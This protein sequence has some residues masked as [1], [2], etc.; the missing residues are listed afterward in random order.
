MW[1]M[2]FTLSDDEQVTVETGRGYHSGF[3]EGCAQETFT[4]LDGEPR[5][6]RLTE[7]CELADPKLP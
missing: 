5:C 3:A 1:L 2:R 7:G 4:D 6:E